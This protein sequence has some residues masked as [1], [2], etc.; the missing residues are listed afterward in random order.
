MFYTFL[1]LKNDRQ[2]VIEKNKKE[3]FQF[4]L[5]RKETVLKIFN[6][7]AFHKN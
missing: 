4:I 6:C 3:Q 2:D 7:R 1:R 5:Y